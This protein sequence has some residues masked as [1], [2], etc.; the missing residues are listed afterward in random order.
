MITV[1]KTPEKLTVS[2][3]ARYAERGKD[4]VCEVLNRKLNT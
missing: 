1:T 3:H 4:V 2:G